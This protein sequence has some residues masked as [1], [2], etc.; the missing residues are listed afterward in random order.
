MR[1]LLRPILGDDALTRHLG[2][3]EARI[4]VEWL[5]ERAECLESD[6]EAEAKVRALC[7]RARG[8]SLFVGLWCHRGQPGAAAQLAN[9]ERFDWPLPEPGVDPD[10]LMEEILEHEARAAA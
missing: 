2:D 5:V 8:I 1:D 3:S 4:L 9:A 10:V 6:A 7:R